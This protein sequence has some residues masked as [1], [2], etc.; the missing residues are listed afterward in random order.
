M[1]TILSDRY[2]I[3]RILPVLEPMPI[4]RAHC[5]TFCTQHLWESSCL[6][7]ALNHGDY[8]SLHSVFQSRE[9]WSG[10]R[11]WLF[12]AVNANW[13]CSHWCCWVSAIF[14]SDLAGGL[15]LCVLNAAPSESRWWR[16]TA[17]HGTGFTDKMRMILA[18]DIVLSKVP[19]SIPFGTEILKTSISR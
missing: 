7:L 9:L 10:S 5:R 15:R 4:L 18:F 2:P 14:G 17:N 19:T 6:T 12:I 3:R 8:D 16:F 13:S 11:L 1:R